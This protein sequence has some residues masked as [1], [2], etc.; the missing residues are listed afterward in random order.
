MMLRVSKLADYATVVMV[1]LARAEVGLYSARDIA[2]QTHLALPTVSKLLKRL[3]ASALLLSVRGV[4]GGYR[5]A[6]SAADIT[7]AEILYSLDEPRGLT[8]CSFNHSACVL[9][10]VCQIQGN[11]QA[12]SQ[13]ID[14]AL[15]S[16]SLE[17]LAKPVMAVTS[18]ETVKK[19]ASGVV[20][21]D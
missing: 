2:L 11:W 13:A 14:A 20:R 16:V 15:Q 7:V 4:T 6:R 1:Y 21:C 12:I 3:T 18:V 19:L 8:A 9:Q 5:L 10:G 17:T